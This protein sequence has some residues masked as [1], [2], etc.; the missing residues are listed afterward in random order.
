MAVNHSSVDNYI[1]KVRVLFFTFIHVPKNCSEQHAVKT[2]EKRVDVVSCISN[3][4]Y[5]AH[6]S[7]AN[8][9][10][11]ILLILRSSS[12]NNAFENILLI[13]LMGH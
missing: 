4:I 7:I 11:V 1:F 13:T 3:R 2:D 10:E 8:I 12:D 6:Q 5:L 9:K